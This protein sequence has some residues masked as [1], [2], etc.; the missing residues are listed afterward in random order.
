MLIS[1]WVSYFTFSTILHFYY[2]S[3][4]RNLMLQ[5]TVMSLLSDSLTIQSTLIYALLLICTFTFLCLCKNPYH[6]MIKTWNFPLLE[7]S[8]IISE[9]YFWIMKFYI[10]VTIHH[11]SRTG[12]VVDNCMNLTKVS[13]ASI[14][15]V[16]IFVLTNNA[17]FRSPIKIV[18]LN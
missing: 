1:G 5:S 15:C 4:H 13:L 14:D 8:W 9:N 6:C 18:I 7:L 3:K 12:Y 11:D 2:F 16:V 17:V 10:L